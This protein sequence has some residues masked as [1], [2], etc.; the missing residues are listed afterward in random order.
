MNKSALSVLVV[1]DEVL[2]ALDIQ[3]QLE[4]EG[5]QVIGPAGS[6]AHAQSLLAEIR[7]DFAVLDINLGR[8]TSFEIAD[9]LA[10]QNIPFVF[11]SGSADDVLPDR[12]R[13]KRLLSKPIVFDG[14][15]TLLRGQPA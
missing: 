3:M 8:Q 2:I 15:R 4:D 7:P 14:L 12:F 11:L 1:E 9:A 6:V 5:W 13:T 10:D